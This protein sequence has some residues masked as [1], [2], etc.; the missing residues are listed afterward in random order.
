MRLTDQIEK[1]KK[2]DK[3]I[4]QERKAGKKLREIGLKHGLSGARIGRICKKQKLI[5]R[6]IKLGIERMKKPLKERLEDERIAEEKREKAYR[7]IQK[8]FGKDLVP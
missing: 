1:N 3:Q 7:D 2:R 8:I 6:G 5:E 4:F